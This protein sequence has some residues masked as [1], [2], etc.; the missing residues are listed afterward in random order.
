M[1]ILL[2][3]LNKIKSLANRSRKDLIKK[4]SVI[5]KAKFSIAL[6]R[7]FLFVIISR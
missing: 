2:S 4:M 5:K 1:A 3:S 7:L 6:T